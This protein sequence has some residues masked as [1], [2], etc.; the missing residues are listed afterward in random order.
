[1]LK[2]V[3][4]LLTGCMM[5]ALVGYAQPGSI[6]GQ[7][8]SR[9]PIV[10]AVPFLSIAPDS[11]SA[12][13]GDAGGA[14]SADVNA[15]Y[16]NQ[17]K[18]AFVEKEFGVSFSFSPWLAK[19]VDDMWLA[20]LSGYKRIDDQQ[21]F[22][23]S[24]RYFDLGSITFT[25]DQ[26]GT[27]QTVDPKEFAIDVTYARKL[28]NRFSM[29][30]AGRFIHS[31]LAG[32]ISCTGCQIAD[33][34]PGNTAA[35]DIATFYK[36]DEMMLSG[37]PSTLRL[38]ATVSNLGPKL[39]YTDDNAKDFIPTNL[40][41][42]SALTTEIDG[43]NKVTL[44]LD[45]NKLLVP[46]PPIYDG[47]QPVGNDPS[48]K[49]LLAGV[50]GSFSDAPDGFKEELQEVM[51]SIGGEYWYNDLLAVRLGYFTEH[52]LKGAR[53]YGT[54]GLGL[55]YSVMS[56]DFAYLIATQQNHPLENTLRFTLMVNFDSSE[57]PAEK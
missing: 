43:F 12:G 49:S 22:G 31:N 38:G 4:L 6:L 37:Y 25:N 40:R 11:R 9:R 48:D 1:M 27:I 19:I 36:N 56:L 35:I 50:F 45:V 21:T 14:V 3:V 51:L 26:G 8:S 55:R 17:A 7:D 53:Q 42:S 24:L 54:V 47:G 46:S 16:W 44:A 57:V 30:I 32:N 34:S 15:N 20:Y 29:A 18:L 41:L 10:T 13:M 2:K 28:S 52:K 5:M 33:P 39:S 23:A